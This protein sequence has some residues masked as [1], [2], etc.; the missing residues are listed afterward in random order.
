MKILQIKHDDFSKDIIE[1]YHDVPLDT[2]VK[3]LTV[4]NEDEIKFEVKE[5]GKKL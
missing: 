4:I 5:P 3:V 1:D 2:M